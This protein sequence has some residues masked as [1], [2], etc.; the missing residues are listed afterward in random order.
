MYPSSLRSA[1]AQS[2]TSTMAAGRRGAYSASVARLRKWG[3]EL[4]RGCMLFYLV[5]THGCSLS[6][7]RSG[8]NHVGICSTRSVKSQ[9]KFPGSAQ[10]LVCKE[11]W[12][13]GSGARATAEAN[14]E[15]DSPIWKPWRGL[16]CNDSHFSCPGIVRVHLVQVAAEEA[17]ESCA[18]RQRHAAV[19]VWSLLP[20]ATP[21]TSAPFQPK[22]VRTDVST[23][24]TASTFLSGHASQPQR[25]PG[26]GDGGMETEQLKKFGD[27]CSLRKGTEYLPSSSTS[28]SS[29]ICNPPSLV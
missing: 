29:Q 19:E 20:L 27:A 22:S 16:L 8:I 10:C 7:R 12:R 26:K 11:K 14:R 5:S 24:R 13:F 2:A 18:T 28:P 9:E 6:S 17:C 23:A 15:K 25:L 21:P 4:I 3:R 1:W